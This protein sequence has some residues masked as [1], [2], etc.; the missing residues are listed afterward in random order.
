MPYKSALLVIAMITAPVWAQ[1]AESTRDP[2]FHIERS[3]NSNIV[4]YD[5]QLDENGNLHSKE[6]VTGYWIRH[7]EQGQ[8]EKLSWAQKKLAYGFKI[9]LNSEKNTAKMDMAANLGRSITIKRAD[10]DYKAVTDIDGVASYLD[11][12]YIQSSGKGLSTKVDYIDLF[13]KSVTSQNDQY[14]RFIPKD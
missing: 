10:N 6:P 5:A 11:K 14:E 1:K 12:I 7:N 3:K 2:L 13:G 8:V 9:K 4:Q